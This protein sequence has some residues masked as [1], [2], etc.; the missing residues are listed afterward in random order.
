[1]LWLNGTKIRYVVS[2][3]LMA[4]IHRIKSLLTH[5]IDSAIRIAYSDRSLKLRYSQ[6]KKNLMSQEQTPFLQDF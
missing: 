1:M 3:F 5:F 6:P 2:E 4:N